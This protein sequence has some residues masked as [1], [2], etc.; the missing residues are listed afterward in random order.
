[1]N[2]EIIPRASID[3]AHVSCSHLSTYI[4]Y[5]Q[6]CIAMNHLDQTINLRVKV[7][8]LL[9]ESLQGLIYAFSPKQRVLAIQLFPHTP[10]KGNT[11]DCI[12][13]VNTSFIKTIQVLP[14]NKKSYKSPEPQKAKVDLLQLETEINAAILAA[15]N[16]STAHGETAKLLNNNGQHKKNTKL[17]PL[18]QKVYLRL[19]ELLGKENVQIQNNETILLFKEVAVAKPYALTKISNSKKTQSSKH[20][21]TARTALREVWMGLDKLKRGG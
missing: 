15:N 1:M 2:I 17:S 12:K 3:L 20:I 6:H 21:E 9:D 8:N 16:N 4:N 13:L 10:H 11:D 5:T 18:A 19:S 7:T 14:H